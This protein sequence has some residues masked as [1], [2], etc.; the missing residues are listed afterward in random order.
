MTNDTNL[1]LN[2]DTFGSIENP[3]TVARVAVVSV[4]GYLRDGSAP[5]VSRDCANERELA[6]EVDRLKHELDDL[7][8]Q[9]GEHFDGQRRDTQRKRDETGKQRAATSPVPVDKPRIKAHLKVADAMTRDV[10]TVQR[11]DPLSAAEALMDGGRFRHVVVL[12]EHDMLAGV[13]SHRDMFYSRLT[14]SMGQGKYAHEKALA[15]LMVKQI[16]QTDITTVDPDTRL[17]EAAELMMAGKIGCLPVLDG[18]ALVGIL[19][20]SDFLGILAAG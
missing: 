7:L 9:A 1:A 11:N 12:D 10:K 8:A 13:I 5:I 15:A 18:D 14:R 16:M 17:D 4:S 20:S 6:K 3:K 2:I 19:T